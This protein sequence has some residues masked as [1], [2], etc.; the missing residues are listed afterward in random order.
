MCLAR[1]RD[2]ADGDNLLLHKLP[3]TPN[4]V[5]IA[6]QSVL[7]VEYGGRHRWRAKTSALTDEQA[8]EMDGG[9]GPSAATGEAVELTDVD[10]LLFEVL[11]RDGRAGFAELAA[12]SG[13]SESA[14]RRR[15]EQLRRAGVLFFEVEVEAALL[16]FRTMTFLRMAVPPTHLES[17]LRDLAT[18]P[19]AAFVAA[20]T[21]VTNVAATVC[22]RDEAD[23]YRYLT[24][25]IAALDAVTWVE[26][27]PSF[28][29]IKR[30]GAVLALW[31]GTRRTARRTAAPPRAAR[32]PGPVRRG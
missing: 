29:Q 14:A 30:E 15:L 22:C 7:H 25:R 19:E 5:D 26:S 13:L 4:V 31:D 16:G 3:R 1:T 10:E 11:A 28:R 20:T 6:A 32:E 8:A 23:V 17:V 9:H 21:G 24:T 2:R 18:H 12:A 27:S